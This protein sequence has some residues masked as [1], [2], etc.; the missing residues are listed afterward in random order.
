MRSGRNKSKLFKYRKEDRCGFQAR[1]GMRSV[2]RALSNVLE[3]DQ[4]DVSLATVYDISPS[5]ADE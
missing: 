4:S 2:A 3:S 1:N 5:V